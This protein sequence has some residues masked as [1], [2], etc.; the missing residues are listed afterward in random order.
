MKERRETEKSVIQID[1]LEAC[2]RKNT[3]GGQELCQECHRGIQLGVGIIQTEL[4]EEST[5]T[6]IDPS[7]LVKQSEILFHISELTA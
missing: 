2:K 6:L 7:Q 5:S 1:R 4:N 3:A